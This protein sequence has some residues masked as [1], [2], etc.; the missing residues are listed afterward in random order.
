MP[1]LADGVYATY[2]YG[3]DS[4][5]ASFWSAARIF[6]VDHNPPQAPA[7]L[8]RSGDR[9]TAV[10]SEPDGAPGQIYVYL[11]GPNGTLV[12]HGWTSQ[13]C[14]GC[15]ASYPL[16]AMAPGT[17]ALYAVASDGLVSPMTGPIAFVV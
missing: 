9:A 11:V 15:T 6:A 10:Y 4:G 2:A 5:A 17:Y 1:D 16:P 14:S 12:S 3:I 7:A 13:V 8:A